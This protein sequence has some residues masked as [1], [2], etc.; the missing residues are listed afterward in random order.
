MKVENK[1]MEQ[2]SKSEFKYSRSI[3]P[4]VS[5]INNL[6]IKLNSSV[7]PFVIDDTLVNKGLDYIA[8]FN[9]IIVLAHQ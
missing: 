6:F 8:N 5:N 4:L 9:R 2:N 7:K 1:I 3:D